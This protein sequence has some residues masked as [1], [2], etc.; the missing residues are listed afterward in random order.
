MKRLRQIW[1]ILCKFKIRLVASITVVAGICSIISAISLFYAPIPLDTKHIITLGILA[2]TQ[3][4]TVTFIFILFALRGSAIRNAKVVESRLLASIELLNSKK[5]EMRNKFLNMHSKA[6]LQLRLHRQARVIN[7]CLIEFNKAV[8]QDL[9]SLRKHSLDLQL[10]VIHSRERND[11]HDVEVAADQHLAIFMN[12]LVNRTRSLF[13]DILGCKSCR[14]CVKIF[15]GDEHHVRVRFRDSEAESIAE[16][17]QRSAIV[18]FTSLTEIFKNSS[19][20]FLENDLL[21]HAFF[22]SPTSNWEDKFRAMLVIPIKSG[23][24][25]SFENND[26]FGFLFI[27]SMDTGNVFEKEYH[28]SLAQDIGAIMYCAFSFVDEVKCQIREQEK[29]FARYKERDMEA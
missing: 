6:K 26:Y 18:E 22:R 3:V 16:D 28:P 13:L 1:D 7:K 17:D 12:Q 27:S 8:N 5:A 4:T 9:A 20:Y 19:E 21:G 24:A 10:H 15:D 25:S 11:L 29:R 23:R 2:F 14:V